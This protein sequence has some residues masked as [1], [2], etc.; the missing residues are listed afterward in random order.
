MRI[1]VPEADHLSAQCTEVVAVNSQ[2][3]AG[4]WELQLIDQEDFEEVHHDF[5]TRKIGGLDTP[6]VGPVIDIEI[7]FLER[8][9]ELIP[10]GR[11]RFSGSGHIDRVSDLPVAELLLEVAHERIDPDALDGLCLAMQDVQFPP[12]L[13]IAEVSPV[14]GFV[15]GAGKARLLDEGFEQDWSIGVTS[16]PVIGQSSAH[17]GE[18]ARGQVFALDPRQDQEAGIVD[19]QMQVALALLFAP[20]DELIPGFDLPRAR[21][22]AQGGNDVAG[23]AH[24]VTQL[25]PGHELM[26]EVMVPFDIGIPE[27]RVGLA[28]HRSDLQATQVDTRHRVGAEPPVRYADRTGT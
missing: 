8:R 4:A 26:P 28:Q 14:G 23:G 20:A 3:L 17:Q 22:E 10:G 25:R 15:A 21:P 6:S 16:V 9:G 24:E 27:E 7:I 12:A 5:S 13:R 11:S 1:F 2:G 18:D 19:D